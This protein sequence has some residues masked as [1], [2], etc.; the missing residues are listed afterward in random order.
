MTAQMK[1]YLG[2]PKISIPWESFGT[3]VNI[4]IK[5]KGQKTVYMES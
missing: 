3:V 1:G 5:L 4:T 2:L